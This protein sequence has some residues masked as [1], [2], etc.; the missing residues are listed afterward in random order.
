MAE[1]GERIPEHWAIDCRGRSTTDPLKGLKGFVLPAG[2]FKGY[3]LAVAIDILS[4]VLTGAAYSSGVKSLI[5]QWE[6]PQHIGHFLIAIDPTRFMT[7]QAFSDRMKDLCERLRQACR[8]NSE[9][10]IYVA[11]DLESQM[12]KE[13]R[14]NGIP[15]DVKTLETLTGFS[16]GKYDYDLAE[17]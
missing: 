3:G 2:K 14:A 11:G 9:I 17:F 10:P 8:I 7:W 6:E 15:I 1:R 16:Q 5:Q 13:R 4:G 12:E